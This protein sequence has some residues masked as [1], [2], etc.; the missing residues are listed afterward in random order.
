LLAGRRLFINILINLPS[1]RLAP[2]FQFPS[3]EIDVFKALKMTLNISKFDINKNII[4]VGQSAG[5]HLGSLL[6]LNQKLQS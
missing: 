4:I 1:Y 3:Q 5:A 6:V 2:D